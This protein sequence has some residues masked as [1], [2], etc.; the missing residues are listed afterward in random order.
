[1]GSADVRQ[2]TDVRVRFPLPPQL[3]TSNMNEEYVL[4]KITELLPDDTR[5]PMGV[6]YVELKNAV[7]ADLK[8]VMNELLNAGKIN[9]FKT[10]NGV[11]VYLK[12]GKMKI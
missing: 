7:Q 6:G 3:K 2:E 1:M 10:L 11:T 5:R 4:K 12:D 8:R 9:Y